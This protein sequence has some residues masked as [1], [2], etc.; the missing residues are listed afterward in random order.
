M[1][2]HGRPRV[3]NISAPR[4]CRRLERSGLT[5][6]ID[7]VAQCF[8]VPQTAGQDDISHFAPEV[9]PAPAP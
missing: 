8:G 2:T 3:G 6:T 9:L 5:G 1:N 7:R 4:H